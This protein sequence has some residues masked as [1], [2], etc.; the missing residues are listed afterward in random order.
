MR[1]RPALLRSPRLTGAVLELDT[2]VSGLLTTYPGPRVAFAGHEIPLWRYGRLA[3]DDAVTAALAWRVAGT[4]I[5]MVRSEGGDDALWWAALDGAFEARGGVLD[6]AFRV[7]TIDHLLA[8]HPTTDMRARGAADDPWI[9]AAGAVCRA[10]G[11][12][13]QVEAIRSAGH[14]SGALGHR[15]RLAA[16]TLM[17]D[18]TPMGSPELLVILSHGRMAER[19]SDGTIADRYTSLLLPALRQRFRS[20]VLSLEPPE[21]GWWVDPFRIASGEYAALTAYLRPAELVDRSRQHARWLSRIAAAAPFRLA[22]AGIEIEQLIA[23][24]G[25]H[26]LARGLAVAGL[27]RL[28][29]DRAL[30]RLRPRAALTVEGHSNVGRMLG[31]AAP[32]LAIVAPQ[33]GLIARSAATNSAFDHRRLP[34][35]SADGRRGCPV[36]QSTLVWGP[37]YRDVLLA[38]GH[39]PASIAMAGL[40]RRL[41]MGQHRVD[42]HVLFVAGSNPDVCA[43]AADTHEELWTIGRVAA[44]LAPSRRLVVR[45]HP[46]HDPALFRRELDV[47]LSLPARRTLSADLDGCALVIGKSSTA[48]VEAAAAGWPVLLV[49]FGPAGDLTGLGQAGLPCVDDPAALREAITAAIGAGPVST[50]AIVSASAQEAVRNTIDRA[51]AALA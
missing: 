18:R 15:L 40:P 6:C 4:G 11:R 13:L 22:V 17:G 14:G 23:P 3:W 49:D 32:V 37:Y 33:G 43:F 51:G 8:D 9:A 50:S 12:S 16:R 27:Y 21:P 45:L 44:A 34:K 2:S 38:L 26:L 24:R 48:L 20:A 42:G 10:R 7:L 41:P 36:P 46:S 35:P 47:P 31:N 30:G 1:Q 25:A 28:A 29:F 5:E 19:A 39:D